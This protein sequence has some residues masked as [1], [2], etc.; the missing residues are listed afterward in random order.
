MKTILVIDDDP[1]AIDI[2][3][4]FLEQDYKVVAAKDGERG[5]SR[6]DSENPPDLILLDILMPGL[7]GYAVCRKLKENPS[8]AHIP[9]IFISVL[10]ADYDEAKGLELGAV[11]YI[12]KPFSPAIIHARVK[13]HLALSEANQELQRQNELLEAEVQ[14]RTRSLLETN[15]ALE[16]NEAKFRSLV[17]NIPGAIYR[18]TFDSEHSIQFISEEIRN[19]SGY[20]ADDFIHNSVRSF[21]SIIHPDDAESVEIKI[22]EGVANRSPY[23]L[24]YRIVN[25]E[26]ETR[27]VYEKGQ[28]SY[29][30]DTALW[31][32]GAIFD[33]TV[34]K[35]QQ[36]QLKRSLKQAVQAVALTVEKR[37]P[38][39]SGHQQ[40]V[41][42]LAATIATAMG[43]DPDVTEG[44][45][46]GGL[47]H[48][49]GKI[50]VPAEIL[51]R[52]GKL[53]ENEYHI[54][55][56]HTQVGHD[57]ISKVDFPWPVKDMIHQHH[58]RLDGSGYPQGLKDGDIIL[59]A[60]ILA[61]ADVVEAMASHRPYRPGLGIE[62]ALE[63][64][65][66]NSGK[67]YDPDVVEACVRLFRE[68]NY[69]LPQPE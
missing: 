22:D 53:S 63:E 48:D 1:S 54:I 38:Y 3:N 30:G 26:G 24:D 28:A 41:A 17:D 33:A 51:N 16:E 29:E 45:R 42:E 10:D 19:I 66:A 18:C 9:V 36:E 32:D 60:R 57:I 11:D 13:T 31:L 64:I 40:R 15:S 21:R 61:V 43:V 52:P 56:T 47:I 5:L 44:V 20:P 46:M 35:Q 12:T 7:D 14:K 55:H 6:A 68:E 49:I 25:A 62:R 4:S 59:E 50:Y 8:T 23:V 58:E 27:W 67:L 2:L 34:E 69:T 37:D 65:E 39:T